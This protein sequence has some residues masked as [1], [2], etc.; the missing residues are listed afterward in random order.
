[1]PDEPDL[2]EYARQ[3][4]ELDLH[5]Y[6]VSSAREIAKE[7]VKAAWEAGHDHVVLIHGARAA[8]HPRSK[9][10]LDG[11]GASSG[12]CARCFAVASS[13]PMPA[14]PALQCTGSSRHG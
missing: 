11:Y 5:G 7:F 10:V 9:L 1:M 8:R 13:T 6:A 4:C 2:Y 12:V 14:A 3:T